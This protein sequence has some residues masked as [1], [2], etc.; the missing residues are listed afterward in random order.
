MPADYSIY[1][2]GESQITISGG[3]QLDGVTQGSGVH[4]NGRTITLNSNAWMP[5]GITDNDPDFQDSDASQRLFGAQTIDGVNY[6]NGTIVE[7]EYGISVTDGTSTWQLVGFNLNTTTPA[8][9]TVE[10][11]A[12][13]GGPGGFPPVGVALRVVGTQEGPSFAA[14]TYA[15]PICVVTGTGIL[16]PFGTRAVEDIEAGDAVITRDH[17]VQTVRWTGARTFAATGSFAPVRFETGVLGNT[18]PL[19]V[20]QQHR[21]LVD[22]WQAELF[23]GEGP[24]LVPAL[25]LVNDST[26]RLKQSGSV[27]YH[28]LLLDD[29]AVIKTNGAWTESFHP[30]A[31]ALQCVSPAARAELFE[32]MPELRDPG[33]APLPACGYPVIKRH[34][35]ALLHL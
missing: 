27:R 25:H 26:V 2:L 11:L 15:T 17:G 32:I 9:G 34:E 35:A 23:Y 19:M 24:V 33:A 18:A 28:H 12:F 5:V 20:S 1:V 7:A 21:M 30:G 13:I 31:Q 14:T 10:G 22:G 6:A 4:L 3:G 16:T 8:Y 29:H